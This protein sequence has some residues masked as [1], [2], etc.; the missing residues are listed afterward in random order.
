M[1]RFW[2]G[3]VVAWLGVVIATGQTALTV[4]RVTT[5]SELTRAVFL[6]HAPGDFDRVF[7]IEQ[8]LSGG[9]GRIRVYDLN[10]ETLLA[11]PFLVIRNVDTG[12]EQGLLGLAFDPDYANN[13]Y[14]Y[15]NYN[16]NNGSIGPTIVGVLIDSF[17]FTM[18]GWVGLA[19][20]LVTSVLLF[21]R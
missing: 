16:P 20:S 21:R 9:N 19:A 15:V 10:S 5:S 8:R 1:N 18:I 11:T 12:N 17:G 14:F 7:I 4:E 3:S 6:T 2:I 13:G